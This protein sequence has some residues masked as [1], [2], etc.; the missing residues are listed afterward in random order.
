MRI[1]VGSDH[2]GFD[3]K[4]AM[5]D[6]LTEAGHHIV[7]LG[8]DSSSVS[9]DYPVYGLAVAKAVASGEAERGLC[10]C[11]TGIGISIAANKV[12]GIRAALVHDGTTAGLA[13][14]HNDANVMCLG[15]RT[16]GLAEAT[17]AADTFFAAEFDGG[18]HRRRIDEIARYESDRDR[19]PD[20][21]LPVAGDDER[22]R[23]TR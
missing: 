18:R 4:R 13:R 20:S 11:G 17:D 7:D 15:G 16:V 6:H 23:L 9:V 3:L 5:A 10:V 22:Q 12:P 14:H 1:A 21:M 8:T 2:A 19:A